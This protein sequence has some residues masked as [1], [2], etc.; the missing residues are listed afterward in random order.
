MATLESDEVDSALGGKLGCEV[1]R[2]KRDHNWYWVK[3]QGRYVTSTKISKGARHTLGNDLVLLMAR[4]L[5]L[6]VAGNL[7]KFVKCKID[8]PECMKI[9]LAT[10]PP[11][12]PPD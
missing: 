6:G 8:K 3:D 4:Q 7:V 12:K 1:D 10:Y 5:G 11:P 2:K 9:I